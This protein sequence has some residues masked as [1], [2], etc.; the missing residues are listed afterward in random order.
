ML[1]NASI[2]SVPGGESTYRL[3]LLDGVYS[4][5]NSL[6]GGSLRIGLCGAGGGA[7]SVENEP[8][9]QIISH[10]DTLQ[11]WCLLY[12]EHDMLLDLLGILFLS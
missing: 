5:L 12:C 2:I 11:L 4:W 3:H 7:T 6:L 8:E 9:E 1:I 10:D